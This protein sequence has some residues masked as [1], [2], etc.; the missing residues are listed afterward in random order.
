MTTKRYKLP[1][2]ILALLLFSS[3]LATQ[4]QA[5]VI[6]ANGIQWELTSSATPGVDSTGT[7]TLAATLNPGWDGD[8]TAWLGA[9]SLQ[10]FGSGVAINGGVI[11]SDGGL[12]DWTNE[13]L[14]AKGC[15]TNGTDDALC[16]Y[17]AG[18]PPALLPDPKT[19]NVNED[20]LGG[21]SPNTGAPF[22]FTFTVTADDPFPEFLHLKV[23]WWEEV[24]KTK[25]GVTTCDG[26]KKA[27]SLISDGISY[28]PDSPDTDPNPVPIPGTF[29][30]LG[31][32]LA[33]LGASRRRG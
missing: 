2:A 7:F 32:G 22:S 20:A 31:L 17:L 24:C 28:N 23:N 18:L 12:W 21:A 15:K 13:G 30:L 1:L 16:V 6:T 8:N 27:K 9:F 10:N 5:G 11:S 14:A 33:S 26:W 3:G 19:G 4:S 29:L 25:K